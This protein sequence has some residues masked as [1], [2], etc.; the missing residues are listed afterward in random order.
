[1][2]AVYGLD[3]VA[4]TVVSPDGEHLYVASFEGGAVAVFKRNSITGVLTFVD[5]QEDGVDGVSGLYSINSVTV[6]Q[7]GKHVYTA[8][9]WA[10]AV[11]V[12]TVSLPASADLTDTDSD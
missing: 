4:S 1:V 5:L 12:F 2:G 11:A 8:A 3:T 6:S 10:D 7:D 9:P